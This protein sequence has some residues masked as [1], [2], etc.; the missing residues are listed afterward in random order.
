[1]SKIYGYCRISTSK[2]SIERQHR[3]ILT[4]Y[5]NAIIIDEAFTGTKIEGRKE[6]N[7]LISKISKGDMI[8][9]DSVSR[10]SRNADEGYKLYEE[11]FNK[12]IDLVF[13]KE[14]H[15]NTS[16]Y[17]NALTNNIEMTGTNV[18]FILEGIN[19]YL[20]ALAKEQI[21]LAFMQS[22]K[23]VSDLHQRTKEGIETARLNGKQIGQ[24]KG[25]KLITKKSIQAKE[26]I[27]KY[28]K[29]FQ[30]SLN[31]VEA[32]KLIGLARNTYYKYKKELIHELE[33]YI[34]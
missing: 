33:N 6:F 26:Q 24:K 13:L 10:M 31:D 23:E 14:Q 20:L 32:M 11:L 15:I 7:K 21:K 19:K 34:K 25:T 16:T 3:N 18:D 17:K 27:L 29:D 30:G 2:Q 8:V 1:M 4:E 12:E 9:F 22:E 28:S 5:P